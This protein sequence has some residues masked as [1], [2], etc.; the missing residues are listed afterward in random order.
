MYCTPRVPRPACNSDD[1]LG[2]ICGVPPIKPTEQ[3]EKGKRVT[4]A[5]SV[6]RSRRLPRPSCGRRCFAAFGTLRA[7]SSEV[8]FVPRSAQDF[9]VIC[10]RYLV[11][12]TVAS[13]PCVRCLFAALNPLFAARAALSLL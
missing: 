10:D 11:F 13:H 7:Q 4:V 5:P 6:L 8:G 9:F 12:V 3:F 2:L 1:D